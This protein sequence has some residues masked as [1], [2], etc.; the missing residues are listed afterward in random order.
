MKISFTNIFVI[1]IFIINL[2]ILTIQCVKYPVTNF[3]NDDKLIKRGESKMIFAVTC[4]STDTI[5][6]GKIIKSFNTIGKLL[7]S[8]ILFKETL[9]VNVTI[10]QNCIILRDELICI[11]EQD[12]NLIGKINFI[13]YKI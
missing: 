6:C 13:L 5:Y 2:Q 7:S 8:V 1:I 11:E 4:V 9:L 3:E 12:V 10:A